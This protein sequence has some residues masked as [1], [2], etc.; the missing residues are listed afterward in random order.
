MADREPAEDWHSEATQPVPKEPESVRVCTLR[1]LRT[2]FGVLA[3]CH[4]H[5][6]VKMTGLGQHGQLAVDVPELKVER[7][8]KEDCPF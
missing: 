3:D 4:A 7:F 2:A 1:R 5:K 6:S 8:E